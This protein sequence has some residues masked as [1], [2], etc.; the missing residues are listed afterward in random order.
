MKAK[1]LTKYL[2]S[3]VVSHVLL[4]TLFLLGLHM[5]IEFMHE[6]PSIGV[7]D[8]DFYHV[9]CYVL[10][11][12]PF[13]IYQ[14]FPMICLLGTVIALGLLAS[15]SELVVM[16][17]SG[18]SLFDI[19]IAVMKVALVLLLLMVLIGEVLSPVAQHKAAQL[20]TTAM[21]GGKAMLTKQG[22]WLYSNGSFIN[23]HSVSND[24]KLHGVTHYQL[25]GD[26]KL[27]SVSYAKD[28]ITK[29]DG[30]V[31]KNVEQTDFEL[32]KTSTSNFSEKHLA[33]NFNPKLLGMIHI[34][35][36]QKTLSGLRTYIKDRL[37]SGLSVSKY[38]F[39]FWQRIFAPLAVLVMLLLAVPFVFVSLYNATMGFRMLVGVMF[40]FGF[41]ILN[42][43]VG[44][45]SVVYQVPPILA[46][47]LPSL[48]FIVIG[49]FFLF[50][51]R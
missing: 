49:A 22:G 14:F 4:V 46:A 38:Q 50:K 6:F 11:M 10:L 33:L 16:R 24:E 48:V 28:G 19:I 13:D 1:I 40:G 27:K 20:K 43:F 39:A 5:F 18:M 8:Y 36:D 44:P 26:L 7:G 3:T 51:V 23:I 2:F 30:W 34:D 25:E 45:M 35:T 12:L 41:Y 42:Q 9:V 37:Q 31:L 32:D 21:S 15:H 47:V 29:D 17:A